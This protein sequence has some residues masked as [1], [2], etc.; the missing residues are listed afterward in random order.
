MNVLT[1]TGQI[2]AKAM[3]NT[4]LSGAFATFSYLLLYYLR[5][6]KWSCLYGINAALAGKLKLLFFET[7]NHVFRHGSRLC[8]L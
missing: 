4:I 7:H 3:V 2:T 5:K 6:R 1:G 8:R